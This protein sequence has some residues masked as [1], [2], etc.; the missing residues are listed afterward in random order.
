[1]NKYVLILLSSFF[2]F[3]SFP[4][5]HDNPNNNSFIDRWEF[6]KFCDFIFDPSTRPNQIPTNPKGVTFNPANV[7]PGSIILV[8]HVPE[9]FKTLAKE[10]QVPYIV[11]THGHYED[12]FQPKYLKYLDNK[13][14]IAWFG[15]HPEAPLK[16]HPKFHPIPLGVWQSLSQKI[17]TKKR[18]F[19]GVF[20]YLRK[21]PK[22][23]L[24]YTNFA[25]N[26]YKPRDKVKGILERRNL[27]RET[28]RKGFEAY[29]IE[30]GDHKFTASPR[31][32]GIDCYRTWEALLVGSIPIVV[33]SELDPAFK[34]LPVLIINSWR[35]LNRKFLSKKYKEITS[36]TYS[37]KKL[38]IDYWKTKI[39]SVQQDFLNQTV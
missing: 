26:T 27:Y 1:M 28:S 19:N 23:K 29:L 36:K 12:A 32:A 18:H 8:R 17:F 5:F 7:T 38:F 21:K 4:L 34:D 2:F 10:I 13:N 9:F 30:M 35:D 37:L 22:N 24:I 15:V 6:A 14:V 25:F 3:D 31:G 20:S 11:V 33:T 39:K 16:N